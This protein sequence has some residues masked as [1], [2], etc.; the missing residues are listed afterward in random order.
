MK[1]FIVPAVI[2][3]AVGLAAVIAAAVHEKNTDGTW[4]E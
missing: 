3:V 1:K 4:R 2:A